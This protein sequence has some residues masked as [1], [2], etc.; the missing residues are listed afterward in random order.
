MAQF[1][2]GQA[3]R[4]KEDAFRGS[5]DPVDREARGR[6]GTLCGTG[7]GGVWGWLAEATGETLM[8]FP[9]ESELEEA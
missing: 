1:K 5:V 2:E 3:V 4:I 9:L 8:A 6:V 7:E